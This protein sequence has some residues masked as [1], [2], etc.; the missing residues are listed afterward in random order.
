MFDYTSNISSTKVVV[1]TTIISNA[2]TYLFSTYNSSAM[3]SKD[4]GKYGKVK[5][6]VYQLILIRL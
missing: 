3:R 4:Y 2:L 6:Y 1:T 5:Y